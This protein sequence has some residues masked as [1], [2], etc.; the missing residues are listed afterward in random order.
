MS[1]SQFAAQVAAKLESIAKEMDELQK[2]KAK[3]EDLQKHLGTGAK[4]AAVAPQAAEPEPAV[5]KPATVPP[6]RRAQATAPK[7]KPAAKP[8]AKAAKS[9]NAKKKPRKAKAARST[10]GRRSSTRADRV[11]GLL[12]EQPRTVAEMTKLLAQEH[13]E[14]AAPETAVRNTLETSLVAK[15]LAHRSKQGRTVFYSRPAAGAEAQGA[16]AAA[17]KKEAASTPA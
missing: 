9:T 16:D 13:P 2:L 11:L 1:D 3:L 12:D 6:A 15:G 5:T 10:T 4:K 8:P 17:P 14:H 7:A